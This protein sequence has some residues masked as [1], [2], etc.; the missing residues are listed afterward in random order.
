MWIA[1]SSPSA[2]SPAPRA[3]RPIYAPD[4]AGLWADIP[5]FTAFAQ[6]VADS[7]DG[8]DLRYS[9]RLKLLKRASH[10]GI[11]RFDANLIIAMVQH[12]MADVHQQR[13]SGPDH[14]AMLSTLTA[15]VVVQSLIIV[16]GW[17]LLS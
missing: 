17:W 14:S 8:R 3:P 10:F 16:A 9:Q 15:V 6:E 11:K 2:R 1:P 12:R 13:E 5:G 4:S 7:L